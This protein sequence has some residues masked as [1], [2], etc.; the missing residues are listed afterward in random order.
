M[1]AGQFLGK[2][3]TSILSIKVIKIKAGII[4]EKVMSVNLNTDLLNLLKS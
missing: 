2:G 4:W 3:T 1:S